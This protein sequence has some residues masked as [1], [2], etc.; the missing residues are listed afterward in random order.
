MKYGIVK[1]GITDS[2]YAILF[3]ECL[4]H[5]AVIGYMPCVSAGFCQV[6]EIEQTDL[7][8][9]EYCCDR[10]VRLHVSVWGESVSLKVKHRPEDAKLILEALY[11]RT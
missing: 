4:T 9:P 6:S 5:K 11:R 7:N 8:E 1:G 2:E 3:D 10:P